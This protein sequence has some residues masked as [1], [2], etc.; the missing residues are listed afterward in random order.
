MQRQ[1][2]SWLGLGYAKNNINLNIFM[3]SCR[4]NEMAD[5]KSDG[6]ILCANPEID[7]TISDHMNSAYKL[8]SEMDK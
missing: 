3:E 2:Q 6:S 8:R 7:T 1:K 4:S 5:D